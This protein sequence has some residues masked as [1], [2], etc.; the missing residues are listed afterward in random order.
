MTGEKDTTSRKPTKNG[1]V[2]GMTNCCEPDS[3]C[4]FKDPSC[5]WICRALQETK[6][7][8]GLCHFRK[9]TIEGPN[10]YDLSLKRKKVSI[11][12]GENCDRDYAS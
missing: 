12:E 2:F 8:D 5:R 1:A 7:S 9:E 10:M 3:S 4:C 6:F 11:F